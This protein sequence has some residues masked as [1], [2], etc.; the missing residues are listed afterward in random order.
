MLSDQRTAAL[1]APG[2]RVVW[3]CAPRLD[4]HAVFAELLGGPVA[5]HF[6]VRPA[7]DVAGV[8]PVVSSQGVGRAG[9]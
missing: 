3:F 5:G 2:G 1:V 4:S 9:V 6:T 7:D 8:A